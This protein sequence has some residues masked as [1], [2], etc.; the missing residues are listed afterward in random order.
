MF[1][2][3]QFNEQ[4]PELV[5]QTHL[6]MLTVHPGVVEQQQLECVSPH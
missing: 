6:A 2:V 4:H 1:A 3:E 5:G